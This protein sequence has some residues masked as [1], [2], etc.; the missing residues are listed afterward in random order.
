LGHEDFLGAFEMSL[1]YAY[2]E[3]EPLEAE[4]SLDMSVLAR[5]TSGDRKQERE[6]LAIFRRQARQVLF[7]LEAMPDPRNRRQVAHAL[8]DR[9]K[10]VGAWRVADAA[11]ALEDAIAQNRQPG[12]ALADLAESISAALSEI[13]AVIRR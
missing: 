3:S 8:T 11:A 7:Q 5:Q 2:D 6:V 9:A 12:P 10:H 4:R 13:D 1:A